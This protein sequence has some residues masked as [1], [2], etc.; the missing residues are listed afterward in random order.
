VR[1]NSRQLSY[2]KESIFERALPWLLIAYCAASLLHFSHNAEY[3][4]D[5]PNLPAWLSRSQV[6]LAWLV[7]LAIGILGY[8]LYRTG[9]RL[10]GLVVLTIYAGLGFDGLLHYTR[11]PFAAH[12]A[13]MNLTIWSEVIA[14]AALLMAVV[15]AL[16]SRQKSEAR[17]P[18][19]QLQ[20][21]RL[22]PRAELRS[23]APQ[24]A[25]RTELPRKSS[26]RWRPTHRPY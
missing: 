25:S 7:T 2:M 5:Y 3:L 18:R 12:T 15:T 1:H 17:R 23:R 14:A 24:A 11:A 9:H 22:D 13:A 6:Y 4:A 26:S 10:I 19:S 16:I 8:V 20:S 21:Q